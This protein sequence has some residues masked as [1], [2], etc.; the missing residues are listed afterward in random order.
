MQ[1]FVAAASITIDGVKTY[2]STFEEAVAYANGKDGTVIVVEN[3]CKTDSSV[4][5]E[6][7]S[8]IIDLDGKAIDST[9]NYIFYYSGG[10]ITILDSVGGGRTVEGVDGSTVFIEGGT[11]EGSVGGSNLIVTDGKFAYVAVTIGETSTI[12]GGSFE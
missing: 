5:F 11:H 3:D 4:D 8:V 9:T 10:S 6:S 7:G 12:S 1:C 2:Y